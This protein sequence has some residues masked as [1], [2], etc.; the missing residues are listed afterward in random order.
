MI[1]IFETDPRGSIDAD[2]RS[3]IIHDRTCYLK[4]VPGKM[5]SDH[6]H[7]NQ[8]KLCSCHSLNTFSCSARPHC[9]RKQIT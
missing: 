6:G 4:Q 2:S 8:R 1:V 3:A 7:L 5:F 9:P